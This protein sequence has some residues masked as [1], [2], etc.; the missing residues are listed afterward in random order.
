MFTVQLFTLTKHPTNTPNLQ[1]SEYDLLGVMYVWDVKEN[2]FS[3]FFK[4]S[5]DL[6]LIAVD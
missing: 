4:Y 5:N 3:A 6:T 2:T 1:N